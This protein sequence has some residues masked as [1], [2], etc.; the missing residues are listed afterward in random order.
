M[1]SNCILLSV[2]INIDGLIIDLIILFQKIKFK[3][4][5]FPHYIAIISFMNNH[6]GLYHLSDINQHRLNQVI[7]IKD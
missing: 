4:L 3:K 5:V 7:G 2:V 1:C 6:C